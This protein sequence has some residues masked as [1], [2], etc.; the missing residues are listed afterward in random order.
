MITATVLHLLQKAQNSSEYGQGF[1]RLDKEAPVFFCNTFSNGCFWIFCKS[2]YL[3]CYLLLKVFEKSTTCHTIIPSD[4]ISATD[5][6]LSIGDPYETPEQIIE[7]LDSQ[8]FAYCTLSSE[9]LDEATA[10]LHLK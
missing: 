8:S 4:S 9:E 2:E 7:Y 3:G 1:Y 10:L 5:S 6:F